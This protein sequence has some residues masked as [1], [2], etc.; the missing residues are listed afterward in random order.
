MEVTLKYDKLIEVWENEFAEYYS[1]NAKLYQ[2]INNV[3]LAFNA[4]D[5]GDQMKLIYVSM[6]L[7]Q[8]EYDWFKESETLKDMKHVLNLFV[9][10]HYPGWKINFCLMIDCDDEIEDIEDDNDEQ[11]DNMG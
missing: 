4:W 2:L 8:A 5:H 6:Y 7:N 3:Q 10:P 11:Q 9:G 1:D